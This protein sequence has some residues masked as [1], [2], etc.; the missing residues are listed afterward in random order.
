MMIKLP[1]KNAVGV[2]EEEQVRLA[3]EIEQ[4]RKAVKDKTR[5]M[6]KLQPNLT[7]MDP[8]C[9]KLLLTEQKTKTIDEESDESD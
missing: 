4:N 5:E 2:I 7:D 6:I 9:V 1:R 3:K 8:Y